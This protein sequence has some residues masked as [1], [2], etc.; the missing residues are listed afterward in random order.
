M[1]KL[2]SIRVL[3][4]LGVWMVSSLSHAQDNIIDEVVWVVGDEA[5]LKSDI[6]QARLQAQYQGIKFSKDPYCVIPE[7]MAVQKLFLHQAEI[8]S[9]EVADTD[10]L[11]M[12]DK[13]IN[14]Y[15]Q[16]VGS[17]EKFEEYMNMTSTQIREKWREEVRNEMIADKMKQEIV[18]DIK[19]TPAQVRRYFNQLPPDSIP[20]IPTQ[21]E[22]QIITQQ[23]KIPQAEIDRVKARLRDFTERITSG[24]TQ[25][26]TLARLY[27]ED[28]GTARQ[29]GEMDFMGRGQL[30]PEFA[31]VA[32]NLTDPK[33]VSKV[34]ETEYGFHIIQLIEKRGDRIKVRHILL[35]PQV[36]EEDLNASVAHLDSIAND[37][38]TGKF[39]FE[40]AALYLSDDKNSKNNNG[41]MPNSATGTSRFEMGQLPQEIAVVVDKMNIG[42][43][44]EAFTMIDAQN[45]K[46]KCAIVKLKT[47]IPGH[48]A[49]ITDDY[50]RLKAVVLEKL[51]NEKIQKWIAEKQKTTYVRINEKWK[52]CDFEYP[53]WIH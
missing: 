53:G 35:K 12:V 40:S 33:K 26:S 42:E 1:R 21:V 30:V 8:D 32:F 10:V 27:S 16:Q 38:R 4:L 19:V 23:P 49:T 37:I 9:I 36:S 25:F 17:K 47:R 45:G 11:S 24:E 43:I 51:Q 7:Q 3:L 6:E 5:I 22:V 14:Y 29:G 2:L 46:E 18:G 44:S 41:L 52:N 15:V 48:K 20:Y 28:P 34:V 39:T 50:H 31:A 13:R